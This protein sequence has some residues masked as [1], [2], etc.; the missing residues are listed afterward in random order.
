MK[1]PLEWLGEWSEWKGTPEELA[2]K[3]TQSGTEVVA[4]RGRDRWFAV[5]KIIKQVILCLWRNLGRFFK[6][7]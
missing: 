5:R 6:M 7:E 3:L 1:V 4:I 2:E